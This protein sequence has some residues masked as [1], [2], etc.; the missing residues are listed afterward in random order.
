MKFSPPAIVLILLG[1]VIA[2]SPW[3]FAPVCEVNGS[4][5]Q[6]ASVMLIP[7]PSEWTARA[8]IGLGAN[9]DCCRSTSPRPK[10][11]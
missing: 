7:M 8:E 1:V 4:Y 9:P 3:T 2:F 6:L 5:A 10:I 11:Q